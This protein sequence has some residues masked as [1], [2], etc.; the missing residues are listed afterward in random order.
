MTNFQ[1]KLLAMLFMVLD[2]VGYI[3]FPEIEWLRIV[4]R[5]SFPLFAFLLTL[6]YEY[7]KDFKKYITKILIFAIIIQIPFYLVTKITMLNIFF[8]LFLGLVILYIEDKEKNIRGKLLIVFLFVLGQLINV[9]Y[10]AYGLI[11]IYLLRKFRNNKKLLFFSYLVINVV[12]YLYIWEIQ[13]YT[14]LTLPIIWA[15]NGKVGYKSKFTKEFFY[16]FYPSHIA[17]IFLI[18]QIFKF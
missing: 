18:Q 15:Y 11:Q 5:L 9:D 14:M 12:A 13:M 2:H 6:G 7:T 4:G 10:G 8:T 16:Y 3:L 17:I 1:I